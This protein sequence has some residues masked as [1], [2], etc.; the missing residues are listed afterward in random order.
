MNTFLIEYLE[1]SGTTQRVFAQRLGVRE[2]TV[3]AWT[4]GVLPRPETMRRIEQETDGRV[5]I[6]SWFERQAS[7]SE[8]SGEAA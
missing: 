8:Q 1:A 6:A 2:A 7:S 4:R 5:P 3:S